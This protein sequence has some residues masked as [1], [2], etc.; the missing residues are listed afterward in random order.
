MGAISA[1]LYLHLL[2]LANRI[3]SITQIPSALALV[4]CVCLTNNALWCF[5]PEPIIVRWATLGPRSETFASS[6]ADITINTVCYTNRILQQSQVFF[7]TQ[8]ETL[9]SN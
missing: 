6:N 2:K 5:H 1:R 9:T 3:V 4:Y 8:Q 7:E